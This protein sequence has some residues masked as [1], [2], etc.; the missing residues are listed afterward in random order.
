MGDILSGLESFGIKNLDRMEVFE[1]KKTEPVKK[2][3]KMSEQKLTEEDLLFEKSYECPCCQHQFKEKTV[4]SGK[5]RMLSQDI[6]LRPR[7]DV[8]DALKYGVVACPLCGY[9]AH[10]RFFTHL[11]P[12]QAKIIQEK[13]SQAF[14]GLKLDSETYS[15]EDAI[16]RHKL[17]LAAAVLKH[18]NVSERAYLCLLLG[19]LV[20][21]RSEQLVVTSEETRLARESLK[22]E[23]LEL[24]S[25]AAEGLTEAFKREHFPICGLDE[26]T[27]TYL[28]AALYF[29]TGKY[30]EA[31]KW[32]SQLLTNRTV[33]NRIKDKARN[34]KDTII[35]MKG[36]K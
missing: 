12:V 29:E 9:A 33:N 6:D 1:D 13:I 17:A 31:S 8:A 30:E 15:Y 35:E 3:V 10:T 23:E 4:R 28:V 26:S 16:G 19:W 27:A 21:G 24:L 32:I 2:E 5:L 36:Q 11:S 22:G 34:L 20:R 14:T 18:S 7:Y 25:K